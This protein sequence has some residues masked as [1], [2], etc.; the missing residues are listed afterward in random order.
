[1]KNK[2]NQ[3]FTLIELLVV[4][5]IIGILSAVVLGFLAAARTSGA[6]SA[7]K[8][9]LTQVSKEAEIYYGTYYES[10]GSFSQATCPT[11]TGGG[12]DTFTNDATMVAIIANA[13]SDGGN[14]SSCSSTGSSYAVAVGLKTSGQSWCTDSTGIDKQFAGTPSAAITNSQCN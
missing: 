11:A 2:S 7:I 4:I 13:V 3:G 6:D 10:Y 12:T 9:D 14:G 1:M 8:A 5:A